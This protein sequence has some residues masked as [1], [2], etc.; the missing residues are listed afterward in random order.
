LRDLSRGPP[1]MLE[2]A[3]WELIAAIGH[4]LAAEHAEAEHFGGRQIRIEPRSEIATDRLDA[5]VTVI[6]LD[7]SSHVAVGPEI[8]DIVKRMGSAKLA[9]PIGSASAA[10]GRIELAHN[11]PAGAGPWQ[12]AAYRPPLL[13]PDPFLSVRPKTS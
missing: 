13:V 8:D 3:R 4:V 1:G 9:A 6:P 5:F 10:L 7:R 12:R 11:P 2:P